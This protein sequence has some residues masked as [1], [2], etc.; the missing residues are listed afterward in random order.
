MSMRALP[1][2]LARLG[3]W[4]PVVVVGVWLSLHGG[5]HARL[6]PYYVLSGIGAQEIKPR[7]LFVL[8]TSGSMSWRSQSSS[9]Q[10][11]W[12]SCEAAGGASQSRI[13]T[14]RRAIRQVVESGSGAASFGLMTFGQMRP[15]TTPP[16][17]CTNG[18]RFRWTQ[19]HGYFWWDW[20]N[21]YAGYNGGWWLCGGSKRPY[22]YLRWDQ[23]GV[24]SVITADD[25]V[26]AVPASPLISSSFASMSSDTNA[27][28]RVQWFPQFMGVRANLNDTTDPGGAIL[29]QTVGDWGTDGATR[30]ANVWGRDFYYWPYVDGFPGYSASVG[31]PDEAGSLPRLGIAQASTTYQAALYAPF[32]LALTDSTPVEAR[33]PAS[34]AEAQAAVT[35]AVSPLVE[36]GVP[37]LGVK[38]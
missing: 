30:S 6:Q 18:R 2:R 23:L 17:M 20:L 28:R 29:A 19:Y 1:Q 12:N 13:S 3:T 32:Y 36:G 16:P 25:R 21:R 9:E 27:A 8:D 10:C 4:L 38:L 24:G 33:G 7:V 5:A 15:P 34:E 11:A 22:A 35:W 37:R 31:R 26:G 14:A